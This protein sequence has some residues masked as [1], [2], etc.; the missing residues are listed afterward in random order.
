MDYS[1][2]EFN[3]E[4]EARR[5]NDAAAVLVAYAKKVNEMSKEKEEEGDA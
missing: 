5:E 4:V 1:G 2:T 3:V